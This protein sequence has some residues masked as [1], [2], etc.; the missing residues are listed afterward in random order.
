M[1][2]VFRLLSQATALLLLALGAHAAHAT[3][4]VCATNAQDLLNKLHEAADTEYLDEPFVI[5]V[6]Q[7]TYTFTVDIDAQYPPNILQQPTYVQGGYR[8]PDCTGGR[9]YDSRKTV[10]DLGGHSLALRQYNTSLS[11]NRIQVDDLTIRN[12]ANVT[13]GA[14]YNH[15][16]TCPL[17]AD[18]P[19]KVVMQEVRVTG[20][21]GQVE[22]YPVKSS[23]T[24]I[25]VVF[26]HL[27]HPA[28]NCQVLISLAN[29]LTANL[30]HV[31]ADLSGGR[32]FCFDDRWN[33]DLQV[34]LSNSI[35]W[36]SDGSGGQVKG[37]HSEESTSPIDVQLNHSIYQ[38]AAAG[39]G[40]VSTVDIG[41]FNA[42]VDPQWNNPATGDYGVKVSSPAVDSGTVAVI[43]GESSVD[44]IGNPRRTAGSPPDRGAIESPWTTVDLFDVTNTNDSGAGSL[45]AAI[46]NANNSAAA[47]AT[48]RF[49]IPYPANPQQGLCPAVINL[50]SQLPD[51]GHAKA[52]TLL[53]DGYTQVPSRWNADAEA[54]DGALCVALAGAGA[55]YGLRVPAQTPDPA[56]GGALA[57]NQVS[58]YLS[59]LGIGNFRNGVALFGGRDHTIVGNQFGGMMPTTTGL[60]QLYG[61]DAFALNVNIPGDAGTLRIGGSDLRDRNVF[62]NATSFGA[63]P[64]ATAIQIGYQF[65]SDPAHCQIIGNT[66][67]V[68]AD[69]MQVPPTTDYGL[70]LQGDGCYVAD[71]RFAGMK[72]DAIY[73]NGGDYNVVQNNTL[74]LFPYGFDLS[75]VNNGSGIRLNG[76]HNVV[77]QRADADGAAS[78]YGNLIENMANA[79]IVGMSGTGNAIRGNSLLYNGLDDA[80]L[81][82]DLGEDGPTQNDSGDI[83]SG[84][85]NRQ[86]YPL[87]HSVSYAGAAPAPGT[88]NFAVTVG[89]TLNSLPGPGFYQV[90]LYYDEDGCA[91]GGRGSARTWI[92]TDRY[93][94]IAQGKNA[95]TFQV[96]VKLP[97]YFA[98]G[99]IS[100]TATNDSNGESSTSEISQC[101]TPDVL[102][103][104]GFQD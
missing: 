63:F 9:D 25:N 88:K 26:D 1:N 96:P 24:M 46:T 103:R 22:F 76:S 93:I 104:D 6:Q 90:D 14:G 50:A 64:Y 49:V 75:S 28:D 43:G 82:I 57:A 66:I 5:H 38:F 87:L 48:I 67:G 21:S 70:Q 68:P 74:G 71:N 11:S 40:A 10:F 60:Y 15:G 89:A 13:L 37:S 51:I 72:K 77:G 97:T 98:D 85:N 31:T 79:G 41:G 7:G 2:R 16:S 55:N 4:V 42:S 95:V 102:F 92:G 99:A 52:Q 94:Y 86:N 20:V 12:A 17:C 27:G 101:I 3:R 35:I 62:L 83:D 19:G 69:G 61:F 18:T 33:G 8:A 34:Y 58:L 56:N 30:N 45:R 100:I 80:D 65:A 81:S 84:P 39:F 59:G 23:L 91:A 47:H 78:D 36:S 29:D 53:I 32:N 44:A 73:V 54:F